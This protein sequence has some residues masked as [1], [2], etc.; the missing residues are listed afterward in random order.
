[1]KLISEI[2]EKNEEFREMLNRL[3]LQYLH[4]PGIKNRA[5]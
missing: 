1:M 5:E 2:L 3:P 4:I